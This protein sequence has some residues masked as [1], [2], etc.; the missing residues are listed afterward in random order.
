TSIDVEDI[1]THQ[2][3]EELKQKY[4]SRFA[5]RIKEIEEAKSKLKKES[6]ELAE[7]KKKE[8]EIIEDKLKK[9]REKIT[10][11]AKAKAVQD[12]KESMEVLLKSLQEDL[13]KKKAENRQL[14]EKEVQFLKK[15]QELKEEKE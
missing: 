10:S 12:A 11:E 15:E 2:L 14:Q 3:E 1:L 9:E 5:E 13:E 6:E 8:A 4:N 7:L